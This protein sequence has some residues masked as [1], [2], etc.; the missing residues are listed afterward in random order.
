MVLDY[1]EKVKGVREGGLER[2][3][4]QKNRPRREPIGLLAVVSVVVLTLT[5]GAGVGTGWLLFKGK[6]TP[7]PAAPQAVKQ[8]APVAP[9][10]PQAQQP[11]DLPDTQLTFYKTLPAGG[12]AALGSGLNLKKPEAA[13][14]PRPAPAAAATPV[15]QPGAEEKGE[16]AAGHFTV[17][18][19]SYRDKK[20][21]DAAQAKLAAKGVAA[22]VVESKLPEKGVW[23]RIRVGRGLGREEAEA[24]AGKSGKGAIVISE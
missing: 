22:F 20:E 21:A 1:S 7:L 3:P 23:Y 17:Q 13:P 9:Q 2:K 18:L 10:Q 5:F 4:V 12:K 11:P 15:A 6:K 19:A 14:A 24:L 16:P 8:V